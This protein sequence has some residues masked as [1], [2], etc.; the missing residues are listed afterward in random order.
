MSRRAGKTAR[1]RSAQGLVGAHQGV[2]AGGPQLCQD[3]GRIHFLRPRRVV[4]HLSCSSDLGLWIF[5]QRFFD[6]VDDSNVY[7]LAGS[8][9]RGSCPGHP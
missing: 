3:G 6:F 8:E 5:L 4:K 7:L 9:T 1:S 2:V